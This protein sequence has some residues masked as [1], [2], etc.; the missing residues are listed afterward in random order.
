MLI[1]WIGIKLTQRIKYKVRQSAENRMQ[2]VVNS[3]R[4][5]AVKLIETGLSYAEIGRRLAISR[6]RVLKIFN[7]ESI[8]RPDLRTRAIMVTRI[9][10]EKLSNIGKVIKQQRSRSLAKSQVYPYHT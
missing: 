4:D 2:E 10:K 8:R 7:T 6:L 1:W 3:K 5:Q 9:R